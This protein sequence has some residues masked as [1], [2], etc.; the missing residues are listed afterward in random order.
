MGEA[1]RVPPNA[2]AV[3]SYAVIY[4][5]AP[6]DVRLNHAAQ[7]AVGIAATFRGPVVLAPT[8][9]PDPSPAH[10][11]LDEALSSGNPAARAELGLTADW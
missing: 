10:Q 3:Q 1:Y 4:S 9:Q 2:C 8:G 6:S 5:A 11:R 7:R